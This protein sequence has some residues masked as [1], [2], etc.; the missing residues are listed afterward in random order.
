MSMKLLLILVTDLQGLFCQQS[1][2]RHGGQYGSESF[3]HP[4]SRLTWTKSTEILGLGF[5]Q[6]S[7]SKHN[8]LKSLGLQQCGK[9][10]VIWVAE[11]F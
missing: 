4:S 2:L 10:E 5:L 3:G 9:K 1:C 6:L 7:Y 8:F 11:I